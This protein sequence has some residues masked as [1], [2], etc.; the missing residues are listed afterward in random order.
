MPFYQLTCKICNAKSIEHFPTVKAMQDYL[1]YK[2]TCT[3]G[4]VPHLERGGLLEKTTITEVQ[5]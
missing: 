1:A 5:K 3:L 4:T 2:I